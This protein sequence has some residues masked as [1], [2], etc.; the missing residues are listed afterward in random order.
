VSKLTT[1]FVL[2]I[3]ILSAALLNAQTT[4]T[5]LGT[6]TDKTG[7]VVPNA[8]VTATNAGTNLSRTAKTNGQG[9]YRI[10]FLPIGDYTVE[11]SASGFKKSLQKGVTLEVNVTARANATL[12]VGAV[13]EEIS[14]TA[15][16]PLVNTSNAQIGR[17]VANA[18]ITTLPIVGRNVYTLLSLTAGVDS[19]AN[20]IV[21]GY[22]E[23]RTMINGGVDGGAGSVNYYLDGGTN[24][25]GL[26]N[27]GNIAPNPDAVEEFRVITNSYSAE[28]GRFASGVVNIITKSGT[29]SFHGSVFEFFRNTDLNA[30]PW[31][32]PTPAPLHRNQYGGSFG[33]P[34]RKNK[35]F[36][37]GTYS[38]L[39]QITNAFVNT[40]I[41]PTP[42]E[43]AGNFSQDKT[44]PKDPT[45]NQPFPGGII[46]TVRLDPTALNIL[47]KY[48]P[49]ANAAGNIW[50]GTIP[51]PYDT[52]E[53]LIKIDHSFSEA[54]FL[55]GSYYETSGHTAQSPGG[56]LPWSTQNFTWRQQNVNIS[57][58]ATLNPTL[59]NQFWVSYT[60][61]FGGRLSTPELSLG[62]LGSQYR[63]QGQPSLPQITVTGY[64]TLS[65][66]ISGP[67]AGT[68][69]YSTRDQVSYTHGRHTLKLGGELSLDK[70][71]QQTLLNNYGVFSFSGA[72]TGSALGDYMLGAPVTMNQDAPITA[73]DNFFT[74]AF[75]AQ[76]DIHISPR[77]TLNLGLRWELQ[78][79]PVDQHDREASFEQG[80]QSQ[81]LKGSNV[82]LGLVVVGDKGVTRGTVPMSWTHF[83]PRIGMAWDPIGNGKT[84]I[85]AGA[86]IF[87]GSVSGNEWNSTSNFQP[88]AVR[89]QF[90]TVQSLTNPY[91]LLPG[92]VS[93]FPFSYTPASP[94]FIFP[95]EIYGMALNFKW[96]YT[97]QF[98]LSVQR[99][100]AKG[101][102]VT[103]A[104]VGSFAHRL[105][106]ANDLNYPYYNS[107]ATT[108][109]VNNR[110]PIEPGTLAQIFLVSSIM[111]TSY[112]SM[113]VTAEKRMGRH[114]SAKGFYT[115][116]KSIDDAE[117]ENNTTNGGAQDYRNLSLER[118]RS[119]FDRR[120]V[121]VTS[122]IWNMNYFDRMHPALRA[123]INGWEL[124]S[125]VTLE[126][127]TPF[128]VT[129]GKDNNLDGN[130][131]DRATTV[132]A[133]ALDPHR[134]QS[135]VSAEWFNPAAFLSG[136]NGADGTSSRNLLDAPGAKN[137]DLGVFR[138]FRIGERIM[139]Q[140][141]GEFTNA[142]NIVNL[143][144]PTAS[145]SSS[146]VG[147]IRSA[148][149]M[150]Q[151]QLGLRLTF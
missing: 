54:N 100:V 116:A 110:R 135:V 147:Q 65:Q 42:L 18:E 82:P 141:R 43:R 86:G 67:V 7:A 51:S 31:L 10:D 87:W 49:Q 92:G 60:R 70:D 1:K 120:H 109:N 143:S 39:R 13:T 83:S 98:N 134:G 118:A 119:D 26:R 6:V 76:D 139:L 59:V 91:G 138:N 137:V 4:T 126:S 104:Y 101:F 113:Q 11:V 2:S 55:T 27:T 130:T 140:A 142:F 68:N 131:N 103:A 33:G 71:I 133:P 105:P 150:R 148:S 78:E 144:A 121:M 145:L 102:T 22:P 20:S 46:P 40:A 132:G 88:F 30:N 111:N 114:F 117:L 72:K 56:N 93:P 52:S 81:I 35:T 57:D 66:A 97:Y 3:C 12:D 125:I 128:T 47:N 90:N 122:L 79:P 107:T 146:L 38:G 16:A 34:I 58:T 14:V 151:V 84:S 21:L 74:G 48:I 45:N 129:T 115:F 25:T 94:Q 50:Q 95:A 96:P 149:A 19:N 5:L 80:V 24:M 77:F 124:S 17:S 64:F 23:Q 73:E 53:Y 44:Q 106:F 112:N 108:S 61:N 62:D 29:N 28:Y 15:E 99:E 8:D 69:F 89:E 127:G 9:E 136:A 37:F 41:V 85:R 123:V 63:I 32:S 36:F 75:F